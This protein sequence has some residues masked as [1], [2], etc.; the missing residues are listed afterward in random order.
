MN[1]VNFVCNNVPTWDISQLTSFGMTRQKV[2][3]SHLSFTVCVLSIDKSES[4]AHFEWCYCQAFRK[5]CPL[6]FSTFQPIPTRLKQKI[7]TQYKRWLCVWWFENAYW[8][9]EFMVLLTCHKHNKNTKRIIT[10][11]LKIRSTV[12][13][14]HMNFNANVVAIAI[15]MI[16]RFHM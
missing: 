10:F 5:R 16:F 11:L 3:F 7:D 1:R 2:Q 6:A 15:Q 8:I 9:Y 14:I 4:N 13:W 12:C